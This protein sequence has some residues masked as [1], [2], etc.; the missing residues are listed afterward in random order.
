MCATYL[1]KN[2]DKGYNFA[3]DFNSI[4]GLHKKLWASKMARLLILGIL[5]LLT[6]EY[7]E[8]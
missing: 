7:K 1:W 4:G 2:L 5:G 3:L 8:K 6:W